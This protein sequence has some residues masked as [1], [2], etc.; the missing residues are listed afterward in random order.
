MFVVTYSVGC[1]VTDFN[2]VQIVIY[3]YDQY[4]YVCCEIHIFVLEQIKITFCFYWSIF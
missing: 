1:V 2:F 3:R 4:L